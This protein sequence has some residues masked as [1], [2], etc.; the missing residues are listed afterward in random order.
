MGPYITLEQWRTLIKVVDAGGYAQAAEKLSKSQ[1]AVTYAMLTPTGQ[2]L[3]RRAVAL[4]KEADELEQAALKL[5]AGWEASITLAV[6]I[7]YPIDN[8]MA[9]LNRFGQESPG[10]RIELIESVLGGTAD[11]LLTGQADLAISPQVPAGLLG[12]LLTT[13]RLMAVAQADHPLHQQSEGLTYRDLRNFRHI[14]VRDSGPDRKQTALTV[15][16]EQRWTVSH[17][18]TSIEA[19]VNGYGFVWLP[20][21]QIRHQLQSSLLKPLPLQEGAI[22]EIPLYLIMPRADCAGPGVKRLA[23]ILKSQD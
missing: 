18:A 11:A 20:E 3:Y 4:I 19:V 23:A 14:V 2:M 10:T 17:I 12:E 6:E 1:S 22:R 8:L 9:G 21:A 5:S 13:V 16:I 15:E 7:L